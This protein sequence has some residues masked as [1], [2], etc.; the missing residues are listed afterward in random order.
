MHA[1]RLAPQIPGATRAAPRSP[2]RF[3]DSPEL[4]EWVN[5]TKKRLVE[6]SQNSSADFNTP[7][8]TALEV[9][10][11]ESLKR[12]NESLKRARQSLVKLANATREAG[13]ALATLKTLS[14]KT[15]QARFFRPG[16]DEF[17]FDHTYAKARAIMNFASRHPTPITLRKLTPKL[18]EELSRIEEMT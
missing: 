5:A 16:A 17:Q 13:S 3:P 7:E 6:R 12:V 15:F 9:K 11:T 4:H 14:P 18:L 2:W 1:Y 8:L 10:F